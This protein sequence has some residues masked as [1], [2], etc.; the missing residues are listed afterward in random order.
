LI[1]VLILAD[2]CNPEWPS[3]PAV[4]FK[5]ARAIADHA[6]VV[7]A[8]HVRN[9][10]AI[11]RAGGC[12]RAE[13]VY[14]DT[15]FIARPLHK[16]SVLLRGGVQVSWTMNVAAYYP[17]YIAFEHQAWKRFGSAI[18]SGGFDV[19][20]RLTPM[21][22]T[23]P[24]AMARWSSL[25]FV[26]GPLN[27]GL[28]WPVGF[29]REL[30]RERELLVYLRNFYKILPYHRSTYRCSAAI[31]AGFQHTIDD[32]PSYSRSRAINYPE[33]GFDPELFAPCSRGERDRITFLYVGRLVPYKCPDVVVEAFAG[34]SELRNHRLKIVGDGP[35]RSDLTKRIAESNL[36]S[37]VS[38]LGWKTQPEVADVMREADVFVFPSIREL[39][40]GA[41]VEAMASGCVPV[42]VDYGGPGGL[43]GESCGV[44]V[45]LGSKQQLIQRF[46]IVLEELASDDLR[47][48]RLGE[49]ACKHVSEHFTWD[50][51]A[52]KMIEVYDWV[53]GQRSNRP[54]FEGIFEPHGD[55]QRDRTIRTPG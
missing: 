32:L 53:T 16:L 43:V 41:V 29:E 24:S 28:R 9:R 47:R 52:R 35:L 5:A 36:G 38:L 2:S 48:C 20:H 34:S 22:P 33:V 46:R 17:S 18:E 8:T 23:L 44:K 50:A 14:L 6:S 19:V 27:G 49:A 40:A 13:V 10:D 54:V 26:L 45:P 51:K 15:E 37:C 11:S 7:L 55:S 25:P 1:R 12:G 39:G 4:G 42:V 21:S 3:L 31:L 30:R